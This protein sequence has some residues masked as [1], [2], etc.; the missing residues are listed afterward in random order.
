MWDSEIHL[1]THYTMFQN[2]AFDI[3][4]FMTKH[5][6][7][8]TSTSEAHELHNMVSTMSQ[9]LRETEDL[10]DEVTNSTQMCGPDNPRHA[11][12]SQTRSNVVYIR[13]V[14]SDT[15]A[16][17]RY[18]SPFPG[19]QYDKS[20]LTR[21]GRAFSYASTDA[22]TEDELNDV[23]DGSSSSTTSHST[24][25]VGH[26]H[27]CGAI[28]K[29]HV[30]R[31]C[32]AIKGSC[33]RCGRMGHLA[34][35][36]SIGA[37]LTTTKPVQLTGTPDK[38][39]PKPVYGLDADTSVD[40]NSPIFADTESTTSSQDSQYVYPESHESQDS[41]RSQRWQITYEEMGRIINLMNDHG[42]PRI[43]QEIIR[44]LET[45]LLRRWRSVL[46]E[47]NDNDDEQTTED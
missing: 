31:D 36:C 13:G 20:L 22:S 2:F 3:G 44:N 23:V 42:R 26:C 15:M 9:S 28:G 30:P 4:K 14:V 7:S 43:Y 46:R 47:I 17:D 38:V 39:D 35:A 27:T 40:K 21:P 6:F 16:I 8:E 19:P 29:W 45:S 32:R 34:K 41:E 12:L 5:R 1:R 10:W 24:D 11:S 18:T 33:R 25:G 37:H